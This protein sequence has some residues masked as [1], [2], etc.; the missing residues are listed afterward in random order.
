MSSQLIGMC[1]TLAEAHG[2]HQARP[3]DRLHKLLSSLGL[4]DSRKACHSLFNAI[5]L[6]SSLQSSTA[7]RTSLTSRGSP[8]GASP[9]SEIIHRMQTWPY[10]RSA[11]HQ[12]A[13]ASDSRSSTPTVICSST[14]APERA[15]Q[16]CSW[17]R[18]S[19]G[20][21]IRRN[22]APG[23]ARSGKVWFAWSAKTS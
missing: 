14:L 12:S 7:R 5:K 10:Q 20:C 21:A 19:F 15:A 6:T 17:W 1:S 18:E 2:V 3:C 13:A 23:R 11:L 22:N 16:S 8:A 4:C 9:S